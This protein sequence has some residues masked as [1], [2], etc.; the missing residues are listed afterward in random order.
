[1]LSSLKIRNR[2]WLLVGTAMLLIAVVSLASAWNQRNETIKE[3]RQKTQ[4]LVENAMTLIRHYGD[5][6]AGGKMEADA[7]REQAKAAVGALRYDGDN[8][9][10][11]VDTAHHM[12]RHPMKPE[13]E[14]KDLSGLKD[15]NGVLIV[16][17]AVAAAKRGKG[18]FV[19]YIWP[20]GA[21]S[22]PVPKVSTSALY[23]PWGWVVTTG[24]Y[25]DDVA[26]E[27]R[28]ALVRAGLIFVVA[29]GFLLALAWRIVVSIVRP[30]TKV[31]HIAQRIADGDL[32]QN[33]E[34]RGRDEL[35]SVLQSCSRMQAALREIVGSL[36][37][38]SQDIA[39]MS[40]QLAAATTQLSHSTEDHA[41]A[42]VS[43]AA[44]VEEM[45]VS[46]SQVSDSAREVC[47]SAT[48]SGEASVAGRNII[49]ALVSADTD[50]SRSVQAT[51]EKIRELGELTERISSIVAVIREVAEQT[52]LL[53]LNAAIEAAR[54][55][56]HGRGFAVV[57]DEVR[58][59]AERTANSTKE[60]AETIGL[61]QSV[62]AD[63][64]GSMERVVAEMDGVAR[65]SDE[66][67]QSI[68]LIDAQSQNVL[69]VV[70]EITNALNEQSS[71][72]NDIARR[73][74][75]IA[76]MTEENSAAVRQTASAAQQLESVATVLQD[77]AR[78]FRV[79]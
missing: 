12:I 34:A 54:A 6:A 22:A 13:L 23:E 4:A 27:F 77:T 25:V 50:T 43:M 1:M 69:V 67:G 53:A 65:L 71:T 49:G 62:T 35:A 15:A 51:A 74:E 72:S 70:G 55:G 20:R 18:D 29:A 58:K 26:T 45:S 37:H 78:R 31:Q 40:S 30:L 16:V 14:G 8:Y 46:I 47:D 76:Q 11:I 3:R 24:I 66:A 9:F 2:L 52:N 48:R 41:Q 17:E 64:V 60:I 42:A 79:A 59:L 61:V 38:N 21:G 68:Q 73:V 7:A 33:I 10:F 56:E 19:D 28:G 32:S 75:Q 36:Q 5:L 44:S 63:T 39:A 57:A